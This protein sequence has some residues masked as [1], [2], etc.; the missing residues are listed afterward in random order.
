MNKYETLYNDI[1]QYAIWKLGE[2]HSYTVKLVKIFDTLSNDIKELLEHMTEE[3][4]DKI[5]FAYAD[6]IDL[7]A[8]GSE[9]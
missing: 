9:N 4:L 7:Q 3:Q 5:F 1:K 8:K 6:D 2:N